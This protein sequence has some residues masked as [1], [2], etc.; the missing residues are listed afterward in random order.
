MRCVVL[1][2][3]FV[4]WR[5]YFHQIQKADVFVFY[6]D[7][8]Y[9][10]HG[11]R[12]RNRIKTPSGTRWLTV[13]VLHRGNVERAIAIKDIRIDPH[14]DWRRKHL[15]TLEQSY[16]KA[17]FYERYEPFVKAVYG[18]EWDRLADLTI[19][20]TVM[21]A[22]E[23]GLETR[24]VRSSEIAVSGDR[25]QRLVDILRTLGATEYVTGPSARSYMDE[26]LFAAAGIGVEYMAYDYPEYPQLHPPF[27]PQVSILDLLFMTGPDAPRYIWGEA[28]H[29]LGR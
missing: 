28:D 12:N 7:V 5:G 21:I 10:K 20:T 8:Q 4:P 24:F 23:L 3:S 22:R 19:G 2:P 11:W 14:V 6:D 17:P 1:Q 9:D 16:A 29:A 25:N 15:R 13:P 26:A 18:R 27:D